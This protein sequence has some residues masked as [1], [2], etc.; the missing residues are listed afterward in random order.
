MLI[1]ILSVVLLSYSCGTYRYYQPLPNT[2]LFANEGELH[3]VGDFG[4]SGLS[5]KAA[6]AL[7]GNIGLT[8]MY[9]ASV[10]N[11]RVKEGELGIGYYTPTNPAGIFASGGLGFGS[12]FAYTDSTHS[13]KAYEGDFYRPYLQLTAGVDGGTILG[14]LKG[15]LKFSFKTSYLIYDGQHLRGSMEAIRSRYL[16]LEPAF[17][18][19]IGS[20]A[21]RIDFTVGMPLHPTIEGLNAFDNA[22]TFPATAGFGFRLVLGRKKL[23]Q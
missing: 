4:S 8:A 14:K 12:N 1:L 6:Y 10:F 2:A 15:D 21:F 22:R 18:M 13:V 17:V 7:P 23:G 11:Y 19:G 9:H 3:L 5:A 16:L 20:Q